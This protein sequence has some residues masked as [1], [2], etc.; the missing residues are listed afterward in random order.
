MSDAG[1]EWQGVAVNLDP[2]ALGA[3]LDAI[4]AR[5][6]VGVPPAMVAPPPEIDRA[7]WLETGRASLANWGIPLDPAMR[8]REPMRSILRLAGAAAFPSVVAILQLD[9]PRVGRRRFIFS[10]T[11]DT[12]VEHAFPRPGIHRLAAMADT[13]AV[14]ER[15]LAILPVDGN[16]EAQHTI[17]LDQER[18][19][20]LKLQA[21]EGETEPAATTLR[22]AGLPDEQAALLIDAIRRPRFGGVISV[23]KCTDQIADDARDL[24]LLQGFQSAW[25]VRQAVP[26]EL[27]VTV[28]RA[29]SSQIAAILREWLAAF[30]MQPAGA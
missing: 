30:A 2:P 13:D 14:V 24:A 6:M 11:A 9:V 21:E 23:L 8:G 25:S 3:L 4:E 12:G 15:M 18:F 28:A 10:Q 20:A 19:L 7:T 5:D 22:D 27:R 17:E 26:G 29:T 1:T 16:G